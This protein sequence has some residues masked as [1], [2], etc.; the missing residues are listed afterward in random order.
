MPKRTVISSV[1]AIKNSLPLWGRVGDGG[2]AMMAGC[3]IA[4]VVHPS[5]DPFPQGKGGFSALVAGDGD[6]F[7]D[8]DQDAVGILKDVIVPE[9]DQTVTMGFNHFRPGLIGQTIGMLPAVEFHNQT[10]TPAREIDHGI[11]NR[12]LPRKLHAFKLAGAQMRPQAAFR[13]RRVAT[14]F[15][16]NTGQ[17]LS[18]HTSYTHTQPSP[19]RERALVAKTL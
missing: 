19:S 16:R 9:T 18:R 8:A 5:P 17:S 11:A 10:Q 1:P 15:A 4:D 12:K 3:Y 14:Q 7:A 13:V 6:F 2:S